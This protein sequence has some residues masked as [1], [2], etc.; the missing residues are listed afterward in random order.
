MISSKLGYDTEARGPGKMAVA[1][2]IPFKS[3]E[4]YPERKPD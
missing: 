4:I 2:G 3:D 1:T